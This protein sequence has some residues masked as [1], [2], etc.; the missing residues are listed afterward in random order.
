MNHGSE[1]EPL[2]IQLIQSRNELSFLHSDAVHGGPEHTA[3]LVELRARI[4]KLEDE[5]S[6][7]KGK[8]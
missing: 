4:H 1:T 2:R 7:K 8:A 3:E 5:I 6:L